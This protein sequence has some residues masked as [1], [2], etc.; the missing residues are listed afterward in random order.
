MKKI[1][2]L[3]MMGV[4]GA[5]MHTHA[6]TAQEIAAKGHAWR[7]VKHPIG[8][9]YS[10]FPYLRI[11]NCPLTYDETKDAVIFK[12]SFDDNYHNVG[13]WSLPIKISD[14]KATINYVRNEIIYEVGTVTVSRKSYPLVRVISCYVII[15][16]SNGKYYCVTPAQADGTP[17]EVTESNKPEWTGTVTQLA[18]GNYQI[19]FGKCVYVELTF[20]KRTSGRVYYD[21]DN[22]VTP[23][24]ANPYY[25]YTPT[26]IFNCQ[27]LVLTT[28]EANA[29]VNDCIMAMDGM[30]ETSTFNDRTYAA[31]VKV[32]GSEITITNWDNKGKPHETD[33]KN[34]TPVLTEKEWSGYLDFDNMNVYMRSQR[35]KAEFSGTTNVT[36]NEYMMGDYDGATTMYHVKGDMEGSP[37]HIGGHT[38]LD[39][40]DCKTV[41]KNPTF[42][43]KDY[44]NVKA[45]NASVVT[46][47]KN[48]TYKTTI[49]L[50]ITH[51]HKIQKNQFGYGNG[52]GDGS[53]KYIYINCAL[54]EHKNTAFVEDY[55]LYIVPGEHA[56]IGGADF[57]HEDGHVNGTRIDLE[58]YATAFMPNTARTM[59]VDVDGDGGQGLERTYNL[60]IP[61]ND[62]KAIAA[63]GKYSLYTRTKYTAESGLEDSFH[64][65]TP[66]GETTTAVGTITTDDLD[67]PV[68]Y[69]TLQG[70]RVDNPLPGAVYVRRQGSHATKV[71]IN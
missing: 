28:F 40:S 10:N 54:G 53:Q 59:D 22:Y 50:D 2:L 69:F 68:E 26:K 20:N 41:I 66:L 36:I 24:A 31:E 15:V 30:Q 61:E 29:E 33:I 47:T 5:M 8:Y 46:K 37:A 65:L 56:V 21:K 67:A 14:K 42:K 60:L 6:Y 52:V 4:M 70:V 55:E 49:D 19:D 7:S 25:T 16:G 34:N 11:G 9:N 1:L 58:Q 48:A 62:L 64:A 32:N 43:F 38:W 35:W 3:L 51:S 39:H 18:D 63:D 71:R 57:M 17:I 44:Y 13:D 45:S 27:G 12:T 23:T